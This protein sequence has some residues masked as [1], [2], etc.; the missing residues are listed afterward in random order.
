M[1]NEIVSTR[2]LHAALGR[3]ERDR[4]GVHV[5]VVAPA[6]NTWLRHWS[7]DEDGARDRAATRLETCLAQL[8]RGGVRAEGFVGDPDPLRAVAGALSSAA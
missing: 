4:R 2:A 3:G 6:L 5:L 8:A 7:S 1:A